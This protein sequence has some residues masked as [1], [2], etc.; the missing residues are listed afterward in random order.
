MTA[1]RNRMIVT[2]LAAVAVVGGV[3]AEG[4]QAQVIS[5]YYTSYS[6][7]V[8]YAPSPVVVAPAPVVYAPAPAVIA[9]APVVYAPAPVVYAPPVRSISFGFGYVSGRHC[10]AGPRYCGPVHCGGRSFGFSF[11]HSHHR[12]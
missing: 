8:V 7:P 4:T 6:A 2:G 10:Y 9:P 1:N 12:R 5:T 3:I 11:G